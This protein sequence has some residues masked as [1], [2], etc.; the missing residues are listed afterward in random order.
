MNLSKQQLRMTVTFMV[1]V[2]L[3]LLL[4]RMAFINPP[5]P[6]EVAYSDFISEL[7]AGHL[8]QVRITETQLIG[9]LKKTALKDKQNPQIVCSRIPGLAAGPLA[10]ELEAQH[11][12]FSGS[13]PS[14]SWW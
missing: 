12:K 1:W 6:R 3:A 10:Q 13:I 14:P 8:E 4:L 2:L 5:Q 9:D 11:V 7:K